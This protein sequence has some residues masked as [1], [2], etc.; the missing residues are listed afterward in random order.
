[1]GYLAANG[2]Y[3]SG[4]GD[5]ATNE[6]RPLIFDS[7]KDFAEET[8]SAAASPVIFGLTRSELFQ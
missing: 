7:N 3:I 2:E 1:M 5:G 8:I 6:E 4:T